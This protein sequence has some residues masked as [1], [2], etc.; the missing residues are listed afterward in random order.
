MGLD[1]ASVK[2]YDF[3]LYAGRKG[4]TDRLALIDPNQIFGGRVHFKQGTGFFLCQS[5][6]QM[7]NG[8]E[9]LMEQAPCCEKMDPPQKRFAVLVLQYAMTP[10]GARFLDP[11]GY[12]LKLWRF[13]A[14]KYQL[15]RTI[16]ANYPL[17]NHDLLVTCSE[18][19]YQKLAIMNAKE[20][21][22]RM[23]ALKAVYEGQ[24]LPWAKGMAPK[25]LKAVG[26]KLSRQ[27][28][29]ERLGLATAAP[30]MQGGMMP[31]ADLNDLIP[32]G[33]NNLVMPPNG[34]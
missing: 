25:A 34:K 31:I 28:L 21:V 10:D 26:R 20:C 13:T 12:Q 4:Q 6:F 23:P 24:V 2:A 19:K 7:N 9:M 33:I 5:K 11:F 17:M 1:D 14:E 18:E 16:N 22:I 30:M 29:L 8:Q 32:G 15:L 27:E 3:D